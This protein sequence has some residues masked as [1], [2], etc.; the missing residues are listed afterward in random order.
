MINL[1]QPNTDLWRF[2]EWASHQSILALDTETTGLDPRK[3]KI[4]LLTISNGQ[5]TWIVD[6][7]DIPVTCVFEDLYNKT[8]VGHNLLF[9]YS[10][11]WQLGFYPTMLL[12]DTMLASQ[13][14]Y[15]GLRDE[16]NKPLSH[17]LEACAKRELGFGLSKD[18]Q[19]SDW[20]GQL[21]KEH[22]N[23]AAQDAQI[24]ISLHRSLQH[25]INF[26]KL[27]QVAEV[28]MRCLPA[29]IW[30]S[31]AGVPIDFNKWC[32][33]ADGELFNAVDLE[34]TMNNEIRDILEEGE[35][36]NWS[37]WQQVKKIF[38]CIGIDLPN[39]A[40]ETISQID[41]PLARLLTEY[42]E[43][44][45]RISTYGRNWEQYIC[46]GRI[47]PQWH[48]NFTATGRLSCSSPNM[49]NLP[50]LKQYREC[51]KASLGRKLVVC[52][53]SMIEVRIA[54]KLAN[55]QRMIKA[56]QRGDDIHSL[57]AAIVL[58][59]D[60][61]QVTKA[62]RQIGKSCVFCLIY[63]GGADKLRRYAQAQF[64]THI[65]IEEATEY[66]KRFMTA[67]PGLTKW[68][69]NIPQDSLNTKTLAGRHRLQVD[70]FTEKVNSP[71]QGSGA[72]MMKLALALLWER[73]NECPASFP[74]MAVHDE[75]VL[76]TID[77]EADK[78]KEWVSRA[79]M[80]AAEWMLHPV[81]C[82]VEG[83]VCQSW[84]DKN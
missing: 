33:I 74:I 83:S 84:A 34:Q 16:K 4:R 56:F 47:Y 27:Q 13:L 75:I 68:H 58:E 23:Y 67:Y 43:R 40:F 57:T 62:E 14:V 42:R 55:E 6:S 21:T 66:K 76:E 20:D 36:V 9:D 2:K 37:S 3:D 8:L 22:Y 72:D 18:L 31:N 54:A 19:K 15:A 51:I 70:K 41:H 49:Q 45:K 35:K 7:R 73:R 60:V 10:F 63:G 28:E 25:K 17:S 46:N 71:D 79:M 50:R 65:S 39:T 38:E 61:S 26:F 30:M 64:K 24:L 77:S 52:D 1:I 82:A 5:D 81:L 69:R 44:Q 48:Q 80:D 29:I 32:Y 12:F 59:K 11:L 53:Y 78:A